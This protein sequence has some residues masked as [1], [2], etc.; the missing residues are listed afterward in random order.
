M[1]R[2]LNRRMMCC[3]LVALLVCQSAPYSWA[4]S[5]QLKANLMKSWLITFSQI[6]YP[7]DTA[8]E[9]SYPVLSDESLTQLEALLNQ[10]LD[11]LTDLHSRNVARLENFMDHKMPSN[12]LGHV[13]VENQGRPVASSVVDEQ[14]RIEIRID[15]EILQATFAASLANAMRENSLGLDKKTDFQLLSEFLEARKKLMEAKGKGT[16]GDFAD[17]VKDRDSDLD[18]IEDFWSNLIDIQPRYEGAILFL[19][20]HELGHFVL[21]HHG[22]SCDLSK[23]EEFSS[24]E[25]AADKYAGYLLGALVG[26]TYLTAFAFDS[27][28]QALTGFD[29]FFV[30]AYGRAGFDSGGPVQCSCPYPKTD[31]RIETARNALDA[32]VQEYAR[33]YETD[34]GKAET[35][36]PITIHCKSGK[37]QMSAPPWITAMFGF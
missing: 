28:F 14:G 22:A 1:I 23:C 32:S 21:G 19:M 25:L 12:V 3:V 24:R 31:L 7:E 33:L 17:I 4:V 2:A 11:H 16:F 10:D 26:P 29:V 8:K 34:R 27:S 15:V 9:N 30:D 13:R 6:L 20:A 36:S 35:T 5:K 18:S 37:C